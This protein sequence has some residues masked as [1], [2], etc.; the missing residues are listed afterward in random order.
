MTKIY[1]FVKNKAYI[2]RKNTFNSEKQQ[3]NLFLV[4]I[5]APIAPHFPH[6]ECGGTYPQAE[7]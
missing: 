6:G 5:Y 3:S 1:F 2:A 4:L 7:F